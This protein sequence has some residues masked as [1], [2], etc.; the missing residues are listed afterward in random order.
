MNRRHGDKFAKKNQHIFL[1]NRK[2]NNIK[3][4]NSRPRG[5]PFEPCFM[6]KWPA[7]VIVV[8]GQFGEERGLVRLHRLLSPRQRGRGE[9]GDRAPA[10]LEAGSG[11]GAR[12]GEERGAAARAAWGRCYQ[13]ERSPAISAS[14]S[15]SFGRRKSGWH[16]LH[17]PTCDIVPWPFQHANS[18]T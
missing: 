13:T 11:G 12:V 15:S 3:S 17:M 7:A 14:Q 1:K 6:N 5:S 9:S 4:T 8:A 16:D 10:T 2:N 18:H